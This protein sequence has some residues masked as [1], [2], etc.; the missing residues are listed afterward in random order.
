MG[1]EELRRNAVTK[2]AIQRS[3]GAAGSLPVIQDLRTGAVQALEDSTLVGIWG[4]SKWSMGTGIWG[5]SRWGHAV[6]GDQEFGTAVWGP[7]PVAG[8]WGLSLWGR[9]L[10]YTPPLNKYDKARWGLSR[11]GDALWYE[12]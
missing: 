3:T 6:F 12:A 7:D 1:L 9:A 11:W 2:E 10:F 5:Q 8:L 4:H